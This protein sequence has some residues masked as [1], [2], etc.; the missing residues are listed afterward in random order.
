MTASW[1]QDLTLIA[2]AGATVL[3]LVVFVLIM[4]F[5]RSSPKASAS[6]SIAAI[7]ISLVCAVFLLARHWNMQT[8]VQY[9]N[10]WVVS[11]DLYIPYGILLDPASLLMLTLVAVI[12][13]L[14]QWTSSLVLTLR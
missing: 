9:F 1:S 5:T 12:C 14:V 2:A 3:P 8:P 10:R 4:M 13:F 6:L 11:G 7:A